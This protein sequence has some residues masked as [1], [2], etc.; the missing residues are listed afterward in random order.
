[1]AETIKMCD[2]SIAVATKVFEML[3]PGRVHVKKPGDDWCTRY[4]IITDIEPKELIYPEGWY[5]AKGAFRNKHTSTNGYYSEAVMRN[6]QGDFWKER[7]RY[8]TW[9]D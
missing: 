2:M 5:Y 4:F 3:N 1:M 9:E 6:S 7:A 8:C